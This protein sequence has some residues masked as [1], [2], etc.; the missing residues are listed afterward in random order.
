VERTAEEMGGGGGEDKEDSLLKESNVVCRK[1]YSFYEWYHKLGGDTESKLRSTLDID[2]ESGSM[3][4]LKRS[5]PGSAETTPPRAKHCR[6]Q[7]SSQHLRHHYSCHQKT[8]ASPTVSVS[9]R[10]LPMI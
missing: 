9:F 8:S 10:Q 1:C 4:T 5:R 6:H 3:Q 7:S 2:A